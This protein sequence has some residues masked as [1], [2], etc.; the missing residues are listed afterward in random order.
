MLYRESANVGPKNGDAGAFP[1]LS[2]QSEILL[3]GVSRAGDWT[4]LG[5]GRFDT[6]YQGHP[7]DTKNGLGGPNGPLEIECNIVCW[8]VCH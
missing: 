4:R 2:A 3:P 1:F 5:T 6:E 7:L 8:G